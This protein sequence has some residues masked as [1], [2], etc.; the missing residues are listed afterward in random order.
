MSGSS[1]WQSADAYNGGKYGI[2]RSRKT[3]PFTSFL[4]E[5]P[6]NHKKRRMRKGR[7]TNFLSDLLLPMDTW[8]Y[9]SH[10]PVELAPSAHMRVREH[11]IGLCLQPE[12]EFRV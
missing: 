12:K 9:G 11:H 10:A 5:C 3:A 2:I 7:T 1:F 8:H 4:S 6:N